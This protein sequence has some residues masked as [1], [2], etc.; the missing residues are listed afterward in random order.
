MHSAG[1]DF[2][3]RVRDF[4]EEMVAYTS[5]H[6]SL[7]YGV[8]QGLHLTTKEEVLAYI[9]EH[10]ITSIRLWFTDILGFLK[11]FEVTPAEIDGAE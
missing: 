6:V 5:A 2:V 3:Q 4:S 1:N 10:E 9:K 11:K 8:P 7:E